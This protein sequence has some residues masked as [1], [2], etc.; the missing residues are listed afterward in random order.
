MIHQF[1]I[2]C[3]LI[4]A[5]STYSLYEWV[6][7]YYQNLLDA[8]KQIQAHQWLYEQ[9]QDPHKK[10]QLAYHTD[11]CEHS[12]QRVQ[13][14]KWDIAWEKSKWK[15]PWILMYFHMV[16]GGFLVLVVLCWFFSVQ[17]RYRRPGLV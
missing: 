12:N 1:I 8:S 2:L 13:Q 4:I 3:S 11:A 15:A 9:C 16:I 17:N 5:C 7:I 14:N 6:P 10:E